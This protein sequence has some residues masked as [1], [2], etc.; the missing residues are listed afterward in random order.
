MTP[1]MGLWAIFETACYPVAQVLLLCLVGAVLASRRVNKFSPDARKHLNHMVFLVFTPALVF[2]NLGPAATIAALWQW[3][4]LPFS[5]LINT[6]LGACLGY[7]VVALTKPP[8]H[9][10]RLTVACCAVGNM[11]NL[12]LVLIGAICS[13]SGAVFGPECSS[14]GLAY[15]SYGMVMGVIAMWVFAYPYLE[16]PHETDELLN[17]LCH[18]RFESNDDRGLSPGLQAT[19]DVVNSSTEPFADERIRGG[20]K[21]WEWQSFLGRQRWDR[22]ITPPVSG[23]ICAILVGAISPLKSALFGPNARFKLLTDVIVN[24]AAAMTPCMML[25]LGGNIAEGP[26]ASALKAQTI[27]GIGCVRLIVLPVLGIGVLKCADALSLLPPNDPLFRFVVLLLSAMPTTHNIGIAATMH[28]TRELE[29]SALLFW[30][31]LASTLTIPVFMMLF[32]YYL[33]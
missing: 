21:C 7:L 23:V 13:N 9:L 5:V 16:P 20:P 17:S 15:S 6:I 32:L 26:R 8:P 28:G 29:T 19:R 10:V 14:Q 31:Y 33:L 30:S 25:V 12:P 24:L 2:V 4:F 3:W 27:L 18:H 11:S 22:I 1:A